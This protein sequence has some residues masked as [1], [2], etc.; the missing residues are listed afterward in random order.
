L[1]KLKEQVCGVCGEK[2]SVREIQEMP[3]LE[4]PCVELLRNSQ[5]TVAARRSFKH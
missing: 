3:L 1:E 5:V 2:H 4:I